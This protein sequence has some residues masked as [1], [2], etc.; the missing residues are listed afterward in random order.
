MG[1]GLGL[2]SRPR[3]VADKLGP[4]VHET[5]CEARSWRI[6]KLSSAEVAASLTHTGLFNRKSTSIF[7]LPSLNKF[8]HTYAEPRRPASSPSLKPNHKNFFASFDIYATIFPCYAFMHRCIRLTA[9]EYKCDGWPVISDLGPLWRV[10][11]FCFVLFF[12]SLMQCFLLMHIHQSDKEEQ[13]KK[14][15]SRGKCFRESF[16]FFFLLACTQQCV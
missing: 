12:L 16:F 9:H 15:K 10:I 4:T 11:F 3:T 14:R 8:F 2:W 1:G 6:N 13:K 7:S 5:V